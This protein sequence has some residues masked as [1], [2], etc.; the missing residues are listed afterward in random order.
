MDHY[1]LDGLFCLIIGSLAII[2]R[3]F[4]SRNAMR[5]QNKVWGFK[6]GEDEIFLTKIGA[7]SIG[8]IFIV[9]GI[10]AIFHLIKV[11]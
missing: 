2:F 9:I 3:N 4:F 5:F 6:Y 1:T 7:I 10:F 8:I 11:R